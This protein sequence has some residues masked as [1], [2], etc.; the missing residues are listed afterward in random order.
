MSATKRK[1]KAVEAPKTIEEAV[2]AVKAS[3]EWLTEDEQKHLQKVY[4]EFDQAQAALQQAVADQ[5]AKFGARASF[6]QYLLGKY[7]LTGDEG[8]EVE[9]GRII[10]KPQG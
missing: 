7:G 6:V 4:A 10:R 9:T 3:N 5:Q 1:L 2:E 8:F